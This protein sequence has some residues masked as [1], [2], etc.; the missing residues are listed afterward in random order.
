[1]SVSQRHTKRPLRAAAV[2]IALLLALAGAAY[3]LSGSSVF[4]YLIG[5]DT[6]GSGL[7]AISQQP[8]GEA[9]SD[10]ITISIS[11]FVYDGER[12][13]LAFQAY[14]EQPESAAFI[15]LV[16]LKINGEEHGWLHAT[17][18][19]QSPMMIPFTGLDILPVQRNPAI[20]G[21]TSQLLPTLND[22]V[23]C[24]AEFVVERPQKGLVFIEEALWDN[25]SGY[26]EEQR[27]EME[28]QRATIASLQNAIVAQPTQAN[29]QKWLKEGYT[30]VDASGGIHVSDIDGPSPYHLRETDRLVVRFTFDADLASAYVCDLS[31]PLPI[32]LPGCTLSIDKLRLSPLSTEVDFTLFANEN[33][34]EAAERLRADYGA[35]MLTDGLRLE[36]DYAGMDFMRDDTSRLIQT[37]DGR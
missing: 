30:V 35:V 23:S 13:A 5:M 29:A 31:S 15:R 34:R 21:I 8:R 27:E 6:P 1:M 4:R 14:N 19:S 7:E 3:A 11:G 22:A 9:A 2:A 10:G 25:L 28:D 18:S 36:V 20:G 16:S 17:A 37:D 32:A 33:S 12:L 24:E 26:D